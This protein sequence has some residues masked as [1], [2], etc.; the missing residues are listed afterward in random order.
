[1]NVLRSLQEDIQGE[2]VDVMEKHISENIFKF[3]KYPQ[4]YNLPFD[5]ICKIVQNAG[6]I[7]PKA[8][9]YILQ[10]CNQKFGKKAIEILEYMDM[11]D[12][13]E[14]ELLDI[15]SVFTEIPLANQLSKVIE[16][17]S[18]DWNYEVELSE[19]EKEFMT[20]APGNEPVNYEKDIFKAAKHNNIESIL[21]TI[22]QSPSMLNIQKPDNHFT[23]LNIACYYGHISLTAALLK[24]GA[25][26]ELADVD[27]R[28][29]LITA[30]RK[31]TFECIEL[32]IKNGADINKVDKRGN[33]ALV[34]AVAS[35][36]SVSVHKLLKAG[37]D[38]NL[39]NK[40]E[41]T[42]LMAASKAGFDDIV[43]SLIDYGANPNFK[44][45]IG[46]TPL[47]CAKSETTK[48]V[49]KANGAKE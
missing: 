1:M 45:T 37:A 27:E 11:I 22:A 46:W 2:R 13:T 14:K 39:A 16:P 5:H 32:L 25:L 9:R 17:S 49:L 26:T 24:R 29:P 34:Y 8:G 43:Q 10:Q 19:E 36:N 44:S 47:L 33:S 38:T 4:L 35:G 41:E 20:Y 31:G 28:T 21:F 40:K 48:D 18:L 30:A 15:F 6:K 42:P 23:V 3:A 7:P 12:L